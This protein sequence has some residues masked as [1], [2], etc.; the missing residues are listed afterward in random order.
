MDYTV[1]T[2]EQIARLAVPA[3]TDVSGAHLYLWTTQKYI[4]DALNM[5]KAWGYRYQCL[6]TGVKAGGMTPYSWQYNAE[7]VVFATI[8]DLALNRLGLKLTFT[9]DRREH[10][11]KPDTFYEL[12]MKASPGRRMEWF[13]RQ[14]REGFEVWGD[15]SNHFDDAECDDL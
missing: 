12:V 2:V 15:Q 5:V 11:R 9:G 14:K 7:H 4:P 10:S 8:G 3:K 13:G 1:M 6:L